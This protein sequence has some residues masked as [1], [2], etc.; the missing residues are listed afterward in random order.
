MAFLD[1]ANQ[2]LNIGDTIV[3]RMSKTESGIS[4]VIEPTVAPITDVEAN[5]PELVNLRLALAMP[6]VMRLPANTT[7][8][9]Q[10]VADALRGMDSSRRSTLHQL[11][12]YNIAQSEARVAAEAEKAK[13]AEATKS[14]ATKQTTK[15][16]PTQ[17]NGQSLPPPLASVHSDTGNDDPVTDSAEVETAATASTSLPVGITSPLFG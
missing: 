10:S 5:D 1:T 13:K 6:L 2:V 3:V 9:D 15:A 11:D 14:K 16:A 7:D 12:A 8:I 17:T 4:V